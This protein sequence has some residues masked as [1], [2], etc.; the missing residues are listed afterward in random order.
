MPVY[1]HIKEGDVKQMLEKEF[2]DVVQHEYHSGLV[3]GT[4]FAPKEGIP[5]R[6]VI[7]VPGISG[8]RHAFDFLSTL[9]VKHGY[10]VLAIDLP[11][12]FKNPNKLTLGLAAETITEAVG[13]LRIQFKMK[14][15]GVVSHSLGAVSALFANAGYN[16][17]LEKTIYQYWSEIETY[18]HNYG[19]LI[20]KHNHELKELTGI[21]SQ[22]DDT[23]TKMKK[24]ILESLKYK[25]SSKSVPDCHIFL[26]PEPNAKG[27]VPGMGILKKLKFPA[28]KM[29]TRKLFH[30][31]NVKNWAKECGDPNLKPTI[32]DDKIGWQFFQ[33]NEIYDF[34]DYF[35]DMKEPG[36][37]LTL[38]N[39]IAKF[40]H[41]KGKI[42]FFEYYLKKHIRDVPKLFMY[43][44]W[45]ITVNGLFGV[46]IIPG[47]SG[48]LHS[49]YA[50]MGNARTIRGNYSHVFNEDKYA[51]MQFY[52]AKHPKVIRDII[53]FLDKN[54]TYYG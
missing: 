37:Y 35:L 13:I 42:N 8:F 20:E 45:D 27:A 18:I 17:G 44:K 15:V 39:A 24:V 46:P 2:S 22:I 10:F 36:D 9:L 6:G 47:M 34:L 7:L 14:H 38:V 30:A 51:A 28:L 3:Y 11:S 26:A 53:H 21:I 48:K 5:S 12:H 40:K 19:R 1:R 52:V 54:I 41:Q 43:G 4:V 25:I 32:D 29:I 49:F 16:S 23:Y 33:T 31:P 50:D